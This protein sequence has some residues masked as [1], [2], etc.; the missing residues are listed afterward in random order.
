[1]VAVIETGAIDD[2]ESHSVLAEYMQQ[3]IRS[4][5]AAIHGEERL[6]KQVQL[7]N[8]LVDVLAKANAA[9]DV[10][11]HLCRRAR[12][13]MAVMR[14]DRSRGKSRTADTPLSIGCL[15]TGTRLDPSLVSQLRKEMRTATE[16]TSCARHQVERHSHP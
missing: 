14:K 3:M 15:L 5:L 11:V 10:E 2:G 4:S 12:R 8:R 16:S 13:L 7:C 1:M 6:A 9:A